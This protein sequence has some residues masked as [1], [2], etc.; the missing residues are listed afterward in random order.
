MKIAS[1][2]RFQ[3][4]VSQH[5]QNA[6]QGSPAIPEMPQGNQLALPECIHLKGN[7]LV[8][9]AQLALCVLIQPD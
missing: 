3:M 9:L 1:L 8:K 7:R 2:V 5:A 6:L 4:T